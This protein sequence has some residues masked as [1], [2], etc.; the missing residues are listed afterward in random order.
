M[1]I[2][3]PLFKDIRWLFSLGI[4]G[5]YIICPSKG[6]AQNYPKTSRQSTLLLAQ[7]KP[8]AVQYYVRAQEALADGD[9]DTAIKLLKRG[10][11][12][13]PEPGMKGLMR[14][15]LFIVHQYSGN[16]NAGSPS[17]TLNRKAIFHLTEAIKLNPNAFWPYARRGD[18]YCALKMVQECIRD[19]TKSISRN[20]DKGDAY[21]RRS[22]AYAEI[23]DFRSAIADLKRSSSYYR[24]IGKSKQAETMEKLIEA[25]SDGS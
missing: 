13:N 20:P 12:L 5:W 2:Q 21:W 4:V 6:V 24:Q 3:K 11:Q 8:S 14:L 25:Y 19:H 23:N 16:L 7:S 22:V 9:S 15:S 17:E 18:A 10:L 1:M